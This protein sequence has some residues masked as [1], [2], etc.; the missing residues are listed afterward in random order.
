MENT[1][2]LP[3]KLSST[4]DS[5]LQA[6]DIRDIRVNVTTIKRGGFSSSRVVTNVP[7][8]SKQHVWGAAQII[9]RTVIGIEK[10]LSEHGLESY[11]G[12]DRQLLDNLISKLADGDEQLLR[13]IA[14]TQE[15]LVLGGPGGQRDAKLAKEV[16]KSQGN[17]ML[18][19]LFSKNPQLAV[20]HQL[21]SPQAQKLQETAT[22]WQAALRDSQNPQLPMRDRAALLPPASAAGTATGSY[23]LKMNMD[24][25]MRTIGIVKP[26]NQGLGSRDNLVSSGK[27]DQINDWGLQPG[28]EVLGEHLTSTLQTTLGLPTNVPDTVTLPLA[29]PSFGAVDAS[30][31]ALYGEFKS[32]PSYK[33]SFTLLAENPDKEGFQARI[34]DRTFTSAAGSAVSAMASRGVNPPKA[35]E[36]DEALKQI[37]MTSKTPEEA[38]DKIIALVG[39]YLAAQYCRDIVYPFVSDLK[40]KGAARVKTLASDLYDSLKK[41]TVPSAT[42]CS[43][44]S[45]VDGASDRYSLSKQDMA[46]MSPLSFGRLQLIDSFVVG[47]DRNG[48]NFMFKDVSQ[49]Q[50]LSQ[51]DNQIPGFGKWVKENLDEVLG[52]AS[53]THV[54]EEDAVRI[55]NLA[56]QLLL[57]WESATGRSIPN[58]AMQTEW[59]VHLLVHMYLHEMETVKDIVPIDHGLTFPDPEILSGDNQGCLAHPANNSWYKEEGASIGKLPRR[60]R[61]HLMSLD[62]R[63]EVL[64]TLL[65]ETQTLKMMASGETSAVMN[66]TDSQQKLWFLS[67]RLQQ[68]GAKV[69]A[70]FLEMAIVKDGMRGTADSSLK[71]LYNAFCRSGNVNEI[72]LANLDAAIEAEYDRIHALTAK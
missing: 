21:R 2:A 41:E 8:S 55:D 53:L 18:A 20:E 13:I 7:P 14:T 35:G 5:V 28:Q 31:K 71:T 22:G 65:S 36:W 16:A 59:D 29:H 32:A 33:E 58:S 11:S 70:S 45:W 30:I 39:H 72:D 49:Q 54:P 26:A 68:I 27:V 51:L 52:M 37:L 62:L 17:L 67:S 40:T 3:P 43:L 44:Q 61:A 6:K 19:S 57:E 56:E 12:R 38:N 1:S 24:G 63:Q 15:V 46:R 50:V 34:V 48:G 64:P 25:E 4:L 47:R 10:Q 42:L 9:A 69:N 23:R 60:T 66:L